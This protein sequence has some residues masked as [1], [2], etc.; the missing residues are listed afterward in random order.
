MLEDRTH[1]TLHFGK[2]ELDL[3][4]GELRADLSRI[5]LQR[6]PLEILQ[7]LLERPGEVVT[8]DGLR[9]RLWPDDTFVDFEHG[10][11]AAVRRLRRALHDDAQEPRFVETLPRRGYRFIG[12]V[13]A[14]ARSGVWSPGVAPESHVRLAV[15]PFTSLVGDH[16]LSEGLTEE[17]IGRLDRDSKGCVA[18]I[19]RMSSMAIGGDVR[20]AREVGEL[21]QVSFLLEGG[22]RRYDHRLRISAWLVDTQS[23]TPIWS[24]THDCDATDPLAM[25][26]E[27]STRIV[28]AVLPILVSVTARS[29]RQPQSTE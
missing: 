16:D 5:Q 20:R 17:V 3:H 8:R 27:V 19:S 11:N 18:V 22:V 24:N 28:A 7:M 2:F 10:L 29:G 25:Q 23:E 12:A 1:R 15:L 13:R 21:L 6:Q 14:T 26:I 9:R 4:S